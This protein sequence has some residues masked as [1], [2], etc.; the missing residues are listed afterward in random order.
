M[1]VPMSWMKEY[2]NL[3]SP[4]DDFIERI[5]MSGSKVEGFNKIAQDISNVVVG[6]I[7]NIVKHPDADKL[8]IT[9][10][11]VGEAQPVQI[12]TGAPN[13]VEG[14]F[15]PV[16]LPGATLAHG[17]KIKKGKLRGVAS[18]GM[19]CSVEELGFDRHD[20]PEAPENGIYLFP[21]PEPLGADVVSV[22]DLQEDV[23][24]FEIT[25]NRPDCFSIIGIA[26]EA[27]STYQLPFQYPKLSVKEQGNGETASK[28]QVQIDDPA[29]CQRYAA[30]VIE[31]VKIGPSPRWMRKRLRAAGVRPINNIVDITNYV[32]IEFGQPMHAFA[33][34]NVSDGKIIVRHASPGES[35]TT[36]DGVN[37]LLDPSMLVI[38]DPQKA[39]AVAGVM[40]GENAMVT[41]DTQTILLESA[42]FNGSSVRITAKRLGLR[43]DASSKYE[44]G[45]DPNLVMDSLNRAAQLIEQLG[46][47]EPLHGVVDCYPSPREPK[48][49]QYNP[50]AINKLLGTSIADEAM[51]EIFERISCTV[52]RISHSVMVPTFR[53]DLN[54]MADLAE[55]VARFYGYD[56]IKPTLATGTALVGKLSYSQK[57]INKIRSI[58]LSNGLSEAMVYS[59]E[60]PKVLEKLHIPTDS[61]LRN[62]ILIGNPLGEDYSMMRT[63][64]LNGILTSL[65]ANY[66]R[67]NAKAALFEIGKV[68]LPKALPLTEFPEEKTKLTFGLYG[69][70]V[71]FYSGKGVLESIL[72]S[73]GITENVD[74]MRT[75]GTPYFHPGR[76]ANLTIG[77]TVV[78]EVGEV[79]PTI[80]KNYELHTTVILGI[81]DCDALIQHACL[82]K[83]Y[84]SLPKF[85]AIT[86]DI[87]IELSDSIMVKEIE[88]IILKNGGSY[89]ESAT[90]FDVYKG[91]QIGE[92]KQSVAYSLLFRA[93]DKTLQDEEINPVIEKIVSNLQSKLSAQLR[94]K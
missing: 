38:S 15:V 68:Y 43:T 67:R 22:L 37:R 78:G 9:T 71:D 81:I 91:E 29:L 93:K 73:C 4:L 79:H 2:V 12:V 56:N 46:A 94:D 48:T 52:D 85:P 27:A 82:E 59:F 74:F 55:E 30:R 54:G 19:L 64:T 80:A 6:K 84:Q 31:N 20:F 25:S 47:G 76:S 7:T 16:A 11:D 65:S 24:E 34:S 70:N 89:L 1:D 49:L 92:G 14:A 44:K 41:E 26:R 18:N 69:K 51:A 53:P 13:V 77:G 23:V 10:I 63:T 21:Q 66:N 17:V 50:V 75:E 3:T 58:L 36:L 35:I 72:D 33:L 62:A 45:L 88:A 86:R 83:Q 8:V 87:A 40:G 5:T 90:L 57:V 61:P 42:N 39:L 60:S 28:I 32:M